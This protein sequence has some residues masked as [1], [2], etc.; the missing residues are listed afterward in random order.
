MCMADKWDVYGRQMGLVWQTSGAC[1]ADK[2]DA[3]PTETKEKIKTNVL[4]L[5]SNEQ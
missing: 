2:W 4:F 3:Y 1:M 5:L